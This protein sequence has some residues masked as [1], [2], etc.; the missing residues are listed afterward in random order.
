MTDDEIDL[1]VAAGNRAIASLEDA[2]DSLDDARNWGV[3]DI[4]V[5]GMLTSAV[6]HTHLEKARKKLAR[7]RADLY[8][9]S[10]EFTDISELAGLS[11]QI[12][13]L[14]T[15][16]DILF[17]NW[18]TDITVQKQIDDACDRVDE[19]IGKTRAAVAHIE[20]LR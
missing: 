9:F 15:T 14:A 16:F 20:S 8:A 5:G 3:F 7:A 11:V 1:A 13:A 12:G 6:K 19:A 4:L 18:L 2:A 17:D 10:R